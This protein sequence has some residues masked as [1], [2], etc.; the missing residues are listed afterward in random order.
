M[1]LN[2]V[3]TTVT[4]RPR[5]RSQSWACRCDCLGASAAAASSGTCWSKNAAVSASM[6]VRTGCSSSLVGLDMA[7]QA[8]RKGDCSGALVCGTALIFSPGMSL[9]LEDQGV[10][11]KTGTCKTFDAKADGY[12]RGPNLILAILKA[13]LALQVLSK[14]SWPLSIVKY[15]P[16]NYFDTLNPRSKMYCPL[17][18]R[19]SNRI[20][21]APNQSLLTSATSAFPLTSSNGP[22][23][24]PSEFVLTRL[25]L[26]VIV[27]SLKQYELFDNRF[28][29]NLDGIVTNG[30][31]N[32]DNN[33]LNDACFGNGIAGSH[34]NGTRSKKTNRNGLNGHV[35]TKENGA[36][37]GYDNP[38]TNG[39][40][41]TLDRPARKTTHQPNGNG[42]LPANGVDN[43]EQSLQASIAAYR[44]YLK[45]T[46]TPLRDIAFTLA[47]RRAHK[48]HRVY[49]VSKGG[50]SLEVF[51]SETGRASL[52]VGW[53]FTG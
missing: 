27:E 50:S 6:T 19:D 48:Q 52:T 28:K 5:N 33:L 17:V 35:A 51:P 41:H 34:T 37:H 44:D 18:D 38:Y 15:P 9:A 46:S 25:V 3:E 29:P 43:A 22:K 53:V 12:R 8:I 21:M 26:A 1:P 45:T 39:Q 11:S 10:L 49:G 7:C 42:V 14:P 31:G 16:N 36:A 47:N 32:A 4:M 23:T 20:L 2:S 30:N 24:G 13:P 40:S